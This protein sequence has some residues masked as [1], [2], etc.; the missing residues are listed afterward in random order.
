MAISNRSNP[1]T[2]VSNEGV[3]VNLADVPEVVP[4][5]NLTLDDPAAKQIR[6]RLFGNWEMN[7]AEFNHARDF[8]L[9]PNSVVLPINFIMYPRA[10]V[11]GVPRDEFD[12]KA[13]VYQI[14]WKEMTAYV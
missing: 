4:E 7:W 2:N 14:E 1:L 12:A 11:A 8:E 6:E 9:N 13:F 10:E 3:S 5:E